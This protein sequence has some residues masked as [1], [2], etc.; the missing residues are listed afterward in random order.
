MKPATRL[1]QY[2]AAIAGVSTKVPKPVTDEE[3]Y[4]EKIAEKLPSSSGGADPF[5]VIVEWVED[6]SE[7]GSYNLV[8]GDYDEIRTK[9]YNT[10]RYAGSYVLGLLVDHGLNDYSGLD[11]SFWSPIKIHYSSD[12][13]DIII[14]AR[15]R[16]YEEMRKILNWH[17]DNTI[18]EN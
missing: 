17:P 13:S 2:L 9:L 16:I 18:D 11:Y 14:E 7:D 5:D 15:E 6:G 3:V 10:S 1:Q 12:G 8:R 4:L